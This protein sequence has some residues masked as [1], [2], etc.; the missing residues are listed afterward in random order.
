MRLGMKANGVAVVFPSSLGRKWG[1][2]ECA[3]AIHLL[4]RMSLLIT[5]GLKENW[6]LGRRDEPLR[7]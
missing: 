1:S 3:W 6:R 2:L 7:S 4:L 5:H